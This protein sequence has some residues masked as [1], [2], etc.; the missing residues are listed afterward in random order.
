MDNIWEEPATVVAASSRVHEPLF[1]YSDEETAPKQASKP[2]LKRARPR[3]QDNEN[4]DE[5]AENLFRDV[6]ESNDA[7]S[8]AELEAA[9]A[10]RAKAGGASNEL[11]KDGEMTKPEKVATSKPNDEGSKSKP[12][13]T[14]AKVD[15]QR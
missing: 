9:L 11:S 6:I 7:R 8:S 4:M 10:R 14:I 15:E 13:R 5:F 3:A 2:P 12:A 1:T